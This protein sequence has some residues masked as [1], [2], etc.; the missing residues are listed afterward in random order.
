MKQYEIYDFG[1]GDY[2]GQ[3]RYYYTDAKSPID[4]I[5]NYIKEKGI[6]GSIVRTITD[7]NTRFIVRNNRSSYLYQLNQPM[8]NKK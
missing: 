5:K 2:I 8:T 6:Q 4:A 7:T 1:Q 3:D